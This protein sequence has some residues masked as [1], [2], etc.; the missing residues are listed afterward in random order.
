MPMVNILNRSENAPDLDCES[1]PEPPGPQ[2]ILASGSPRRKDLLTEAG[3]EFVVQPSPGE[4]IHDP[5]LDVMT[6]T[7]RNAEIKAAALE[8]GEDFG[9]VV[10][11][12]AD[13]LVTIDGEALGK[14]TNM[15]E[16]GEM[17][18]RLNGRTHEVMTGVCLL[19]PATGGREA[20]VV[21]TAVT[22]KKLTEEELAA[23]HQLIHP[24]DKA[25]AYAAQEHGERIIECTEGSWTNVVGLPMDETIAA[26]ARF[27]VLPGQ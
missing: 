7:S 15:E 1:D 20:F 4:E 8:V 21:R 23:Y 22:F 26:L 5:A 13:T 16:A 25:G 14:P 19:R 11:L 17:I 6:L 9:D 27:G 3:F 12:A 10:I 2:L 24:L 18:G